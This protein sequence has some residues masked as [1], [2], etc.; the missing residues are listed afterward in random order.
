MNKN[1]Q[2]EEKIL[3]AVRHLQVRL[4]E[5]EQELLKF[6]EGDMQKIVEE[7]KSSSENISNVNF[8]YYDVGKNYSKD[9]VPKLLDSV[10][11]QQSSPD[12]VT[13]LK[14]TDEGGQIYYVAGAGGTISARKISS[15]IGEIT[16]SQGG[17]S[18]RMT[19]GGGGD[20]EKWPMVKEV[21]E[22][23]IREKKI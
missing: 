11:K 10:R 23:L 19:K 16:G 9:Q 5:N 2:L 22:K 7:I 6:K 4:K 14:G 8:I 1:F 17:G 3:E 18:D 12:W 21:V 20:P 13:I 15:K